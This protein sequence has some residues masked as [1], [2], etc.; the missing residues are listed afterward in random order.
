MRTLRIKWAKSSLL[1]FHRPIL[2]PEGGE[3]EY[4]GFQVT[5]MIKW[6]QKSQSKKKSLDQ[7]LTPKISHAEFPSL[8]KF[9]ESI[10]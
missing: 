1:H 8:K 4:T 6:G 7:K 3:G 9:P 5:G 2:Y 10:T